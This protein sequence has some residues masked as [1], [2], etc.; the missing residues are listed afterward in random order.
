MQHRQRFAAITATLLAVTVSACAQAPDSKPI[1]AVTIQAVWS[2]DAKTLQDVRSACAS[3]AYPEMGNC[4]AQQMQ[5]AGASPQ[6]IAFLHEMHNDAYLAKF[7]N[8]GRVSIAWIIYPYRANSNTGCLL[9]NGTPRLVDVDDLSKLP[10]SQLK[11]DPAWTALVAKHPKAM[12]WAADRSGM[13]GIAAESSGGGGQRF[14][15]DYM[16]LDGC[17]AC[18]RLARV[19]YAFDFDNTGR[20]LG[21]RFVDLNALQ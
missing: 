9:V 12:L 2:P 14:L 20:L 17:H 19:H 16:V 3:A 1:P 18:A 21:V 5:K 10:A 6:A 11:S 13:S 4:F 8:T 7:Q 15:V